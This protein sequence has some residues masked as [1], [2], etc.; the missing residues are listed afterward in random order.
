M[1]SALAEISIYR[2][3][4]TLVNGAPVCSRYINTEST[5]GDYPVTDSCERSA[6]VMNDDYVKL[7]FKLLNQT[8][9]EAFSFIYYDNQL[10]FL[11][12]EYRPTAKGAYYQYDMKFVSIANM[13]DKHICLRYMTVDNVEV[14]PEPEINM[15]GTLAEM[16]VI[17]L[18]SIQGAARRLNTDQP[19]LFYSYVL[20]R[21][22]IANDLQ[23]NTTLQTFSF[24]G[25]NIS[26]VLTQ[27]A[28]VYEIEWWI[29]QESLTA[30]SLHLCKCEQGDALVLSD[31]YRETGDTLQPYVSRGLLSCEYS[32]EW[33]NIPQKIIPFGSDRNITRKQAL[34]TINGN[35]MYV[36]YGKQLRLAPNTTYTVTDRNRNAVQKTT[37]ALGAFTNTAVHSCIETVEMFDDIYPRCHFRVLGVTMQGTDNPIYTIT[38]AA[39]KAD[40][41]SLMSYAEMVAAELLPLQ[42]EPNETL[43]IIFESGYLNGREFEVAYDIKEVGGV[44]Q[45]TLTIVP[46]EDGDNGVSLP[47]GNFV[48]RARVEGGYEGDMFAIFHMIMPQGYITR[49][50]EELAQAA[51]DK[52]LAIEDTR[53]EIKCKTEPLFFANQSLSLGK[54]V[55]VHSELF[56][57]IVENGAGEIEPD[58]PSLFVSRVTSFSHS[59]TK[60]NEVEFKLASSRVEGRLAEI[61]AV[62]ADQ[63][64]DIRGLEQRS[65]NLSRRGWHDA[66][67][68]RDMLESLAA[69]M[70]LVGVEKHQFAFTSAIECV[71]GYIVAGTNHFDHLHISAGYIQHTQEPYIKYANG[72]RWEIN[73][74][75]I[76][77]DE[78]SRSIIYNPQDESNSLHLTAFYL[79]AVC[80]STATTAELVLSTSKHE[81][82]TDYLLMGIL[83][84]EFLDELDPNNITSYRVFNRSNGY[85]QIAGG[86]ITTEQIQDPTRSLIIDFASNPPRI[87]AKNGAKIIGNIEFTMPDGSSVQD[88]INQRFEDLGAIGGEN[89]IEAFGAEYVQTGTYNGYGYTAIPFR[90]MVNGSYPTFEAGKYVFSAEYIHIRK[91][92]N[93]VPPN[94]IHIEIVNGATRGATTEYF[95]VEMSEPVKTPFVLQT[96]SPLFLRIYWDE[97]AEA[98]ITIKNAMLQSG[99]IP[100][101]YLPY[102]EHLTAAFKG[103]TEVAGGLL[104]THLLMLKNES[105]A[106]TAGMSGL[107]G[108]LTN[109]EKVLLWGGGDYQAA[110]TAASGGAQLPILITK[111]G[112]GSRIGCLKVVSATEVQVESSLGLIRIDTGSGGIRILKNGLEKIVVVPSAVMNSSYRPQ[113]D[114]T[115]SKGGSIEGGDQRTSWNEIFEEFEIPSETNSVTITYNFNAYAYYKWIGNS[116]V[117]AQ[118]TIQLEH[119]YDGSGWGNYETLATHSPSGTGLTQENVNSYSLTMRCSGS[120]SFTNIMSGKYRIRVIAGGSTSNQDHV[121]IGSTNDWSV[122]GT[123]TPAYEA[124]TVIGTDGLICAKSGTQYFMVDNSGSS[125]RVIARGLKADKTGTQKGEL[126]SSETFLSAFRT[127]LTELRAELSSVR[128]EGKNTDHQESCYNACTAMLTA[129]DNNKI[130]QFNN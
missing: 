65:L 68:M 90:N 42:I 16:S 60:P 73:E 100:T 2:P 128:Y 122:A 50:Q 5:S 71:N 119:K 70:M 63:T 10:F 3:T 121:I 130:V 93:G 19:N 91:T 51:Y 107:T 46:D 96:A 28:E 59:L 35:D 105:N 39:I 81:A 84:S 33:S 95:T 75:N 41:V 9:F 29:T 24:S 49:A 18:S 7:S 40:G 47:F 57:N 72:G 12:E 15:N 94:G 14:S 52:L 26:D 86:T 25:Q 118:M 43:S 83:S 88:Y 125:Q 17:V 129:I 114:L 77:L 127:F 110:L 103:S 62:I 48:P 111:N 89:L 87:I 34:Q 38:A 55:A 44:M 108:T 20:N 82:D 80:R 13:L 54:R 21:M 61:E 30:I 8:V 78:S 106:V 37:D 11:K 115:I 102:V 126:Y 113:G 74:T 4:Y 36:S 27:I 76:T 66:A 31:R 116:S 99:E 98:T 85:T 120:K 1:T 117:G 45:W 67:E 97:N 79:Y 32:Q 23:Q 69:E 124:K 22:T 112:I 56:G 104:M 53:P 101:T 109:P 123:Y 58:S 6:T 92:G 64:S